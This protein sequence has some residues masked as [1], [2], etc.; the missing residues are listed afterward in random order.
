MEPDVARLPTFE[1]ILLEVNQSLGLERPQSK[2]IS[3]F[4]SLE[5]ALDK[6]R[7]MAERL[8]ESIISTL[9]MDDQIRRDFEANL[10]GWMAFYK[11]LELNTW[12]GAAS[13]RQVV[14]YL[15]AYSFVPSVARAVAFLTLAAV[16]RE[17]PIAP[18]MPGGEF[19][20]LPTVN[21]EENR[22]DLPFPRTIEWLL[23]LMEAPSLERVAQS[24]ERHPAGGSALRRLQTWRL[25]ERLPKSA[26]EIREFFHDDVKLE[27]LGAFIDQ[28]EASI[29]DRFDAT[30]TFIRHKGLDANALHDQIAMTAE[31]LAAVLDGTAPV[32]ERE[33]F[34]RL[35]SQ[36]YR[37]PSMRTIRQRMLVARLVQDGYKRLLKFLCPGVS[38]TSADPGRNKLLQLIGL[39][40]TV[41]NLTIDAWKN[42]GDHAGQDVW[43][44]ERLAPWDK[45]DLLLSILPS[46]NAEQRTL[47]LAGRLTRAFMRL[48]PECPLEDLVPFES[49]ASDVIQRRISKLQLETD[50]DDRLM[51]LTERARVSSPWRGLQAENNYSVVSQFVQDETLPSKTRM[52][53]LQRLREL[54][55]TPLQKFECIVAE[56]QVFLNVE[57]QYRPE[58]IH[59]RVQA[60]LDEIH[61]DEP[62]YDV[63]KAPLLRF[64]AKHQLMQNRFDEALADFDEALKASHERNFG[65]LRGEI[66]RDSWAAA[67]VQHGLKREKQEKYYLNM[68]AYG[69]FEGDIASFEDTAAW[70]EE[71]FWSDLYNPY[72]GFERVRG[73]AMQEF[74]L[75]F[76][77]TVGLIDAADW[78]GLQEWMKRHARNFRKANLKD[79]RRNSVLLHWLKQMHHIGRV[80]PNLRFAGHVSASSA[81]DNLDRH[82]RNWREV[83]R[84][85]VETWP[86]QAKIADFKGQTPLM[87]VADNGDAEL[88]RL[89]APMSDID[90][91]DYLGRTAL[92]AAV[93]GRSAECVSAIL[94]H[95][96]DVLKVTYGEGNTALHTAVRFGVPENVRQIVQEFPGLATQANSSGQT[97]L[98]LAKDISVHFPDWA[99]YMRGQNRR[100]GTREEFKAIIGLLDH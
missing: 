70:C 90:A 78:G 59:Q 52:M 29:E 44:E 45:A 98:D 81:A 8:S 77:E 9:D 55:A 15:F 14:W 97:P 72:P 83:V 53:S 50:E 33:E 11:G 65:A 12:T 85:L 95:I 89:L 79:A 41:Y 17:Q 76:T 63:W 32:T 18:D 48:T 31:R 43:F 94:E 64:R 49:S 57:P 71:F 68:M 23:D 6:H 54:A 42:G 96:P 60:L 34:V 92:H 73:P 4:R 1:E 99:A 21:Q 84:I 37:A 47:I 46:L 93:S 91:Q 13:E 28:A 16:A 86:E 100:T 80:L 39:F 74:K 87:I 62:G 56:L 27:F 66:A 67:I 24:F 35:I 38:S 82:L 61:E 88:T 40:H 26:E 20:F 7:D 58:D 51:K 5:M 10:L 25:E 2:Y 69:M 75:V 30:L 36:R 22:V 19:W 3:Q